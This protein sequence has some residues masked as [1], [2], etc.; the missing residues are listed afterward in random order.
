VRNGGANQQ[1]STEDGMGS[2]GDIEARMV[3]QDGEDGHG[4]FWSIFF[5]VIPSLILLLKPHLCPTFLFH[6]RRWVGHFF[7]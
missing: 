3:G 2:E 6:V 1:V 7:G 4:V 5:I